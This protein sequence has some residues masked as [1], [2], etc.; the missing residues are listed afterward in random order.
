M[1]AKKG[2]ILSGFLFAALLLISTFLEVEVFTRA[3]GEVSSFLP[4]AHVDFADDGM[5]QHIYSSEGDFVKKGEILVE[6][7]HAEQKI[8]LEILTGKAQLLDKKIA[9]LN[10]LLDEQAL[11]G[12]DDLEPGSEREEKLARQVERFLQIS[13]NYYESLQN[14]RELVAI[15]NQK[16][17]AILSLFNRKAVSSVQSMDA[18]Q[19]VLRSRK[20]LL[21]VKKD[22]EER[23]VFEIERYE[24]QRREVLSSIRL[25]QYYLERSYIRSPVNG[26]V[27]HVNFSQEGKFISQGDT[28][29]EIIED[30]PQPFKITLKVSA[31]DIGMIQAEK[32]VRLLLD[33]YDHTVF[34]YLDGVISHVS[35]DR[36]EESGNEF[37]Y[38]VEVVPKQ[39]YLE[40]KEQ[41]FPLKYGMTLFGTI[42]R[43]R[44][45][46]I[47]YLMSPVI[48]HFHQIGHI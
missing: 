42:E 5:I 33:A 4:P 18:T 20:D 40:Y 41:R 45:S 30:T 10:A 19:K 22:F 47:S 37:F 48:K 13:N 28:F 39:S 31:K 11:D 12:F 6:L 43:G 23:I 9:I 46:L 26:V 32:E 1:D 24:E 44:I 16:S 34:G 8:N 3:D 7:D 17:Q 21:K 14:L 25:Y 29:A 2:L 38:R 27:R 15:D 36:L 35:V